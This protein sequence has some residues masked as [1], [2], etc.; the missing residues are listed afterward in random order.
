MRFSGFQYQ[1]H[2]IRRFRMP[3]ERVPIRSNKYDPAALPQNTER[4]RKDAANVGDVLC[5]LYA[6]NYVK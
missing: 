1:R 4:L 3:Y 2:A 6:G 5:D